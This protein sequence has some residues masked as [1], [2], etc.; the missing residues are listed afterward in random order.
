MTLLQWFINFLINKNSG[1]T[2]KDGS[3]S[4]KELAEDLH[5][6]IVGKFKKRKV[7]ATFIDNI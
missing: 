7:H 1:G 2:G 5:K 4:N 6:K 3:I